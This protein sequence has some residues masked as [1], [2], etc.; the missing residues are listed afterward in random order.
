MIHNLNK[1]AKKSDDIIT[2]IE[3]VPRDFDIVPECDVTLRVPVKERD[4]PL[5]LAFQFKHKKVDLL[6][7]C[8]KICREPSEKNYQLKF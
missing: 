7:Y 1:I 2:L 3:D 5:L 8:S 6:T 4:P